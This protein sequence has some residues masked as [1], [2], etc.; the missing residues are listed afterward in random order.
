[1][2]ESEFEVEAKLTN[3]PAA[4]VAVAFILASLACS[5]GMIAYCLGALGA[6]PWQ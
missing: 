3:W 5:L 4:L 1:M 6:A 2:S